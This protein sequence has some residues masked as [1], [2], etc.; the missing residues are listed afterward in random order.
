VFGF[1]A[2]GLRVRVAG[3]CPTLSALQPRFES[4]L[5][6]GPPYV[7]QQPRRR[8][9]FH[10]QVSYRLRLDGT[11][12]FRNSPA[13]VLRIDLFG[14]AR[15]WLCGVDDSVI[16]IISSAIIIA[17]EIQLFTTYTIPI[18]IFL[19]PQEYAY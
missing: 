11:P 8:L 18:G 7:V 2:Y 12:T 13:G 16:H 10:Q 4:P 14:S 5:T 9:N 1:T 17:L 3:P 6:S 15:V 19:F